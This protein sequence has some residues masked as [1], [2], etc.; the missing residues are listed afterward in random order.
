VH[1]AVAGGTTAEPAVVIAVTDDGPGIARHDL[2]HVFERL[3]VARSGPTRREAGSGLGL[4]IV[5][6][7]V[8]A[9][10]GTV[11]AHPA[12]P[13]SQL[14]VTLPPAPAPAAPPA[15]PPGI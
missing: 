2:P 5:R 15:G 11:A 9:M 12:E 1:V 7:L 6:E 10:G 14:V 4:A 3:Y 8:T 13:G